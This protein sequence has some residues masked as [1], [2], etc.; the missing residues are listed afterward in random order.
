MAGIAHVG[1]GFALK[2]AAPKAPVIGLLAAAEAL[3]LL[4]IPLLAVSVGT[5]TLPL[6]HG[7]FMAVLWS[8]A[9]AALAALLRRDARTSLVLGLAVFS[10]WILDFITH[11]MGA[12]FGGEP[13]PPDLPIFF[14]GSPKVGLGLYNSSYGLAMAFDLGLTIAGIAAYVAFRKRRPFVTWSSGT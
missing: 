3:D 7:L 1:I 11:P 14:A 4:T 9:A 6:T 10:H 13:L 2:W 12:I 5:D 8:L